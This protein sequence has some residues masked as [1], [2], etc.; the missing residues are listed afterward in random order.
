MNP[1]V[2]NVTARPEGSQLRVEWETPR[3]PSDVRYTVYVTDK[4]HVK[5]A[6]KNCS[7]AS[8]ERALGNCSTNSKCVCMCACACVCVC[9]CAL[10]CVCASLCACVHVCVCIHV[11]CIEF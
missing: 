7:S 2:T 11:V 5:P 4:V 3:A 10:A 1:P 6:N 9:A 8:R